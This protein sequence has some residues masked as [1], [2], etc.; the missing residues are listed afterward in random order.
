MG[1]KFVSP[2]GSWLSNP[3]AVLKATDDAGNLTSALLMLAD[4]HFNATRRTLKFKVRPAR[5]IIHLPRWG[6]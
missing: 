3:V 5:H 2:A 4:P 1:G 6:S